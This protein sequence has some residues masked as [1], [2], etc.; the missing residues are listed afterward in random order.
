MRCLQSPTERLPMGNTKHPR[1][2]FR[3]LQHSFQIG[4]KSPSPTEAAPLI[5]GIKINLWKNQ[6][7]KSIPL[8]FLRK[9]FLKLTPCDCKP[10]LQADQPLLLWCCNYDTCYGFD[11]VVPLTW[12]HFADQSKLL[13]L[14]VLQ[15]DQQLSLIQ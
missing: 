11:F 4:M 3:S 1:Q 14:M 12:D 10:T 13:Q 5:K 8:G 9:T 7:R 15:R 6:T 2:S